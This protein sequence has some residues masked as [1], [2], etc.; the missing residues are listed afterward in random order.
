MAPAAETRRL[1]HDLVQ[2]LP[3]PTARA[4]LRTLVRVGERQAIERLVLA[5]RGCEHDLDDPELRE[6][7][8][9]ALEYRISPA[10]AEDDDTE[11]LS[12]FE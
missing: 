8:F 11:P 5:L 7:L 1:A 4:V 2:W 6:A 9:D 3:T 12:L 10:L